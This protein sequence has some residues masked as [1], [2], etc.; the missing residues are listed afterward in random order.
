[1]HEEPAGIKMKSLGE[2]PRFPRLTETQFSP[3]AKL[4]T[5][6]IPSDSVIGI[7]VKHNKGLVASE[8]STT[9]QIKAQRACKSYE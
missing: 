7:S 3:C 6:N 1:M 5:R 4:K 8:K 9:N 2:L